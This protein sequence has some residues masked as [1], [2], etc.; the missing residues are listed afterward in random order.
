[1]NQHDGRGVLL[2]ED[3]RMQE[4]T[5]FLT[6]ADLGMEGILEREF[7]A[8]LNESSTLAFRV[9]FGV[10]RHREDAEDVAQEALTK[11]YRNFRRLRERDRFRAWLV[12]ITWR[13]AID[14]QRSERRRNARETIEFGARGALSAIE[15]LE[16]RERSERLWRAIDALSRKTAGGNNPRGHSGA[17]YSRGCTAA[18]PP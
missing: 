2:G 11:A 10:L 18:A 17:R 12:R 14:R 1:M 4:Y 16:T 7:E 15:T 6:N 3:E 5:G 9:A 13:L 8:R